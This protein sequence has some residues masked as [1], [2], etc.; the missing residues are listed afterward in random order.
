MHICRLRIKFPE[1]FLMKMFVASLEENAR[2]LYKNLPVASICSLNHFHIVFH[3]KYKED[4]P[5]LL[6]VQ[7]YCDNFQSFI[8]YLEGYYDD[9]QFMNDEILKALEEKPFQKVEALLELSSPQEEKYDACLSDVHEE[10]THET[11]P[12]VVQKIDQPKVKEEIHLPEHVQVEDNSQNQ[13]QSGDPGKEATELTFLDPQEHLQQAVF[14]SKIKDQLNF[15]DEYH[16]SNSLSCCI[17]S[18]FTSLE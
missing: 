18:Q 17:V 4:Y 16:L 14:P 3:D 10:S 2:Y 5:S 11:I 6:L 8:Q 9:D 7:N 13:Q 12:A 15:H 1:D